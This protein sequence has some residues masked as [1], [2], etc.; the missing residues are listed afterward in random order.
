[1]SGKE[2]KATY[3][4]DTIKGFYKVNKSDALF[5]KLKNGRIQ[6]KDDDYV[7]EVLEIK[8]GSHQV[9]RLKGRRAFKKGNDLIYNS[10]R[11][12]LGGPSCGA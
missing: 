9:L 2:F 10:R 5:K 6:R 8:K 7:G 1:M 12:D 3:P 4:H 11:K